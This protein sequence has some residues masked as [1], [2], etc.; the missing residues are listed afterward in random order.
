MD[1]NVTLNTLIDAA[2]AGDRRKLSAT[3]EDLF[4]WLKSG[5]FT[6]RDPRENKHQGDGDD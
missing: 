5:G 2:V 6:P 4:V 1:P 3:A